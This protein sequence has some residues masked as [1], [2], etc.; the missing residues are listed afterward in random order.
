MLQT[1]TDR[2]ASNLHY[3]LVVELELIWY[4][5]S[6]IKA[7]LRSGPKNNKKCRAVFVIQLMQRYATFL[8][9]IS[10]QNQF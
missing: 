3:F 5:Q 8:L 1:N 4:K 10:L 9:L 6:N 7:S 2:S